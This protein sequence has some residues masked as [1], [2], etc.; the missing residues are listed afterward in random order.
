MT[1]LIATI[2]KLRAELD[3]HRRSDLKEYPTRVILVHPLLEALGWDVRDPHEVELEY[4]TIDGKSV[5]YALKINGKPVLFLEVKPINDPLADVRSITQVVSYAAIAG[6]EWCTL[7]NGVTY[8]VYNSYQKA[9]APDKLLFEVSLD[10]R[11]TEGM[12]IEQV[13]G[14]FGRLSRDAM[15]KDVL[16]EIGQAIF[17]TAKV[18]KALDALFIEPP[19]TLVRLIRSTIGDDTIKPNEIRTALKRVWAHPPEVP[20]TPAQPPGAKPATI[21]R[22]EYSEL[23]HT[24][25]KPREVTE[26]FRNL[27]KFC[28][29]LDPANVETKYLKWYVRYSRGKNIFCC[30]H[31]QKSGLRVSLKL[32]YWDLESPPDFARDVSKVGHWGVGDVELAIDSLARVDDA[33]VLILKSF[34]GSKPV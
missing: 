3:G 29:D 25:D 2:E 19:G 20:I 23:D 8:K 9:A 5:D 21:G 30:V 26:L 28:R 31:L 12:S 7:T 14:L 32:N 1:S 16:G 22:K 17:T 27:D 10:P 18:R 13:A 4:A 6:V 34:E 15:A 11:D 24:Q 33:K